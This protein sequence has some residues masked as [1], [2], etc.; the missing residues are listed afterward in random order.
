MRLN[1]FILKAL[2]VPYKKWGSSWNGVDC[3]GLVRL[4]YR[5]V[6]GIELPDIRTYRWWESWKKVKEPQTGD[7]LFI[8][9]EEA[10]IAL[11]VGNSRILHALEKYG[12]RLDRYNKN[13]QKLTK[14]VWRLKDETP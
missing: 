12:V 3:Y 7:V 13:W 5:E 9:L 6:R 1:E 11:Y 8:N 10:H 4:F 2:R 14:S